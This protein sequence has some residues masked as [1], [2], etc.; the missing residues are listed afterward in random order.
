ML[1]KIKKILWPEKQ[2]VYKWCKSKG[3]S[4][5]ELTSLKVPGIRL[6]DIVNEKQFLKLYKKIKKQ[7]AHE[8]E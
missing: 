5:R 1:T 7:L 4:T 6:S 3:H 8:Q 2:T